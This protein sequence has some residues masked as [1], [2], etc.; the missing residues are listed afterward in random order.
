MFDHRDPVMDQKFVSHAIPIKGA[1]VNDGVRPK[2]QRQSITY[3]KCVRDKR[4]VPIERCSLTIGTD[5]ATTVPTTSTI[6][7]ALIVLREGV[8][9][10]STEKTARVLR[11]SIHELEALRRNH[12][13]PISM[14]K[15]DVMMTKARERASAGVNGA[16]R[17]VTQSI[18]PV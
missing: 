1:S 4:S 7:L 8:E 3:A 17:V 18:I 9:P 2:R 13:I 6:G 10:I 16:G 12:A 15:T 11:G 5:E 14:S